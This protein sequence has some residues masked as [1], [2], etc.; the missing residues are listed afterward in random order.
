MKWTNLDFVP[1]FLNSF[2]ISK[3]QRFAIVN[4]RIVPMPLLNEPKVKQTQ[5]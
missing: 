4:L 2:A 1:S 5:G 3:N